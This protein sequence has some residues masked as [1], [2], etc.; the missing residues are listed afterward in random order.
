MKS[1]SRKLPAVPP[2]DLVPE[3]RAAVLLK[4]AED[5]G[6]SV[7]VLEA[8]VPMVA[9]ERSV[10]AQMVKPEGPTPAE[11]RVA[12]E[13]LQTLGCIKRTSQG[14]ILLSEHGLV[15][16]RLLKPGVGAPKTKSLRFEL[17]DEEQGDWGILK[18]GVEGIDSKLR[19]SGVHLAC[20]VIFHVRGL[21]VRDRMTLDDVGD[22]LQKLVAR[23]LGPRSGPGDRT[24]ASKDSIAAALDDL[25]RWKLLLLRQSHDDRDQRVR[26]YWVEGPLPSVAFS[27]PEGRLDPDN[28]R[29][30]LARIAT[31]LSGWHPPSQTP[32]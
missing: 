22:A 7:D 25:V 2:L 13:D 20:F 17:K 15:L 32:V 6:P 27:K 12:L 24:K 1:R 5:L 18:T 8:A 16:A 28:W 19:R 9:R 23:G 14:T 30:Y 31:H 21:S 11:V 4:L 10:L 26:R 29:D 3:L